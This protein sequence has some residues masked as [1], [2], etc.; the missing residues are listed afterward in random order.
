MHLH[1]HNT[2][3]SINIIG[4]EGISIIYFRP[5]NDELNI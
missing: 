1:T 5:I 4:C 2:L 3:Q